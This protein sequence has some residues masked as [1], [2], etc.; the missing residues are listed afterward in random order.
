M[1][2]HTSIRQSKLRNYKVYAHH[3]S[4]KGVTSLRCITKCE[5][6]GMENA[7]HTGKQ[8]SKMMLMEFS[9][10]SEEASGLQKCA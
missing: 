5:A 9:H 8:F 10:V 6:R 3:T 2:K 4:L 1:G 7:I